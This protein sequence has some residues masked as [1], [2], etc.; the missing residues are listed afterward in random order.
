MYLFY[1][2]EDNF[3]PYVGVIIFMFI[4][5][6]YKLHTDVLQFPIETIKCVFCTDLHGE[7]QETEGKQKSVGALFQFTQLLSHKIA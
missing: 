1:L 4:A 3:S 7:K 2:T 6:D 5:V